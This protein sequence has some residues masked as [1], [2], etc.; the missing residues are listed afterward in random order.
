[1]IYLQHNIGDPLYFF[2]VQSEFGGGRQESIILYPQVIW[3]YLKILWTARPFDLKYYAYV[4]EFIFGTLGLVG[5]VWSWFKV[6]KSYV[7]FSALVFLLPTLTGTFSSMP[8]YFL[9]SFSVFLLMIKLFE[10]HKIARLIWLSL[11]TL[12]LIFNTILFI[13]GYWVA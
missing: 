10:H 13:Q 9:A 5:I 7:V 3:R 11:S 12:W 1:M 8:R 2:H 6:R 4:Q